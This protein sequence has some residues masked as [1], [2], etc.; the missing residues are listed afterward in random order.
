MTAF[1]KGPLGEVWRREFIPGILPDGQVE[2]KVELSGY[3]LV[4]PEP[5]ISLPLVKRDS[6]LENFQQEGPENGHRV[7]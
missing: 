3:D 2:S 4:K 7:W 5:S 6:L 1:W